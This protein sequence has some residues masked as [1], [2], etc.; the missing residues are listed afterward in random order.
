MISIS[1]TP[2]EIGETGE[3]T[4]ALLAIIK[5]YLLQST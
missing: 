5:K 2:L 4:R 1:Y 3:I